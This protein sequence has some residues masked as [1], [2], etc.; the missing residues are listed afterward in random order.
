MQFFIKI[1]VL[2]LVSIFLFL[3]SSRPIKAQETSQFITIVNPVRIS[4]YTPDPA[5]SIQTEYGIVLQ[6]KLPATWLLTYDVLKNDS[7]VRVLKQMNNEQEKGLFLE[8][9]PLFAKNSQ[10]EYHNSG[11]WHFA[12][13]VFLS[14]YTQKERIQLIDTDFEAF[15]SVFGYYPTSVGAWWID[16]YSLSYM[17][18]RYGITANL[19]LADQLTTDGYEVWGGYWSTPFYPSKQHA[20]IPAASLES[21]VDLVTTEWAPRD[22]LNGYKDSK[23][24]TQDYSV[25]GLQTDYFEKLLHVFVDQH[26]NQFGHITVGLEADLPAGVYKDEFSKQMGI[27]RKF[28]NSSAYQV[29]N[30]KTFARWYTERFPNVS[31]PQLVE[32]DDL[33]GGENKAFWYNTPQYR[34]GLVYDAQNKKTRIIDLRVYTSDFQDPYFFSPNTNKELTIYIPSVIDS[35]SDEK[36]NWDLDLGELQGLDREEDVVSINFKNGVRLVLTPNNIIL[37]S[38][39]SVPS[40]IQKSKLIVI[41][42]SNNVTITPVS[43]SSAPPEG[44]S[45]QALTPEAK[46]FLMQKKTILLVVSFAGLIFVLIG[47][48]FLYPRIRIAGLGLSAVLI[49]GLGYAGNHWYLSHSGTYWV[50][51]GEIDALSKLKTLSPGKVLVYDHECLQCVSFSSVRQA[52]FVNN[53]KYV[54]QWSGHPIIYNAAVFEGKDLVMTKKDF[55]SQ[56]V[57]YVY[58]VNYPYY[59]EKLPF[60]PGDF[61]I[62]KIYGN[63]NAEI[64]RV[65]D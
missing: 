25:M 28:A 62:E 1:K 56:R 65:K 6:N 7:M 31:P 30:M 42:K 29:T 40:F 10:V 58:L 4:R 61:N 50:S 57:R 64:W 26:A 36:E 13:S 37:P 52:A 60:S 9:S 63:A 12:T 21:K 14:G 41:Q 23:Y 2:G 19:G 43:T 3:L 27:V 20:G 11:F 35:A 48:S 5:E 24:S 38:T 18:E 59:S 39:M 16:S 44:A 53:R 45:I 15:K 32:S 51:Q 17:K 46:H 47:V 55:A 34:I 8:V 49:V 33:L 54:Q 22:P